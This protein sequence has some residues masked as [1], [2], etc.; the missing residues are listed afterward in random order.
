MSSPKHLRP[1]DAI[2][3]FD[4]SSHQVGELANLLGLPHEIASVHTFPDEE[5]LVQ[6]HRSA[7][8]VAIYRSLHHPNPKL[9]EVLLAASALRDIGVRQVSLIA[10]YL[11]YMRQDIAFAPG[12]AVSQRVLGQMFAALF[13][14]FITIDP[15]LHRTHELKSVFCGKPSLAL[16]ATSL[17]A[18]HARAHCTKLYGLVVGPDEE[19]GP[20]VQAIANEIGVK[21]A[22]ATKNRHGDRRVTISIPS[23][24]DV[25]DQ[26]VLIADDIISTGTT[27]AFLASALKFKGARQVDVYATH[28]LCDDRALAALRA[29]GA[30]RI[31]SCDT[32]PHPT[33]E[34]SA[35]RIIAAGLRAS[36]EGT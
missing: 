26:R 31:V 8:H 15:H 1:I 32:V 16:S 27:V 29:A 12:Q 25:K 23:G 19:S 35:A 6:V 18:E 20:F 24:T 14:G 34:I 2:L 21:S 7:R 30:D 33:N 13:D 36:Q 28:A 4:D 17:I 9:F 22:V 5:S 10:P 11:P 3:G